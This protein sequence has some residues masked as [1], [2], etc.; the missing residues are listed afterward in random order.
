MKPIAFLINSLNT[1]KEEILQT[2]RSKFTAT[3]IKIVCSE[4]EGHL[5]TLVQQTIIEGYTTIVI[6]G[7]DGSINESVNGLIDY[8]ST[9]EN[10]N[11]DAVANITLGILPAG[12]G[13]DYAR[14]IYKNG[15]SISI[16]KKLIKNNTT[17]LI[18][19]GKATF[20]NEKN[21]TTTRYFTNIIDV[22]IGGEVVSRLR[23]SRNKGN[24][25]LNYSL[26]ILRSFLGF[27]KP[28][29]TIQYERK[30]ISGKH[31]ALV[32][33][34]GN[35]F[36]KGICIAPDASITTNQFSVVRLG[37]ISIFDYVKNINKLRKGIKIQHAEVHYD[38]VEEL[39][40]TS[41]NPAKLDMDGEA[42]GCT[43]LKLK[44]LPE[45]INI[46]VDRE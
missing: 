32:A 5:F 34:I 20:L 29:L 1:N 44:C 27:R 17:Q 12:N 18:S 13:N 38:F 42:V 2:I 25:K 23:K 9:D 24:Q 22:G 19:I 40:V 11:W 30:Q 46:L 6:V 45:K 26:A 3:P 4:Y 14:V 21:E 41:K 8:Y 33:A 28:N 43:P 35:Y 37:N 31:L 16:L 36:G 7:G 15:F 10:V 39:V